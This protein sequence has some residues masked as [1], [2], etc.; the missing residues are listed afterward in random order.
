MAAWSSG[1][2][3]ASGARG[4][5]CVDIQDF[6]LRHERHKQVLGRAAQHAVFGGRA[7]R[8]VK[9]NGW[10]ERVHTEKYE[11]NISYSFLST[12]LS[13]GVAQWLAC[14]AH[15]P[16]VRGSKPRSAIALLWVLSK[17]RQERIELPT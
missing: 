11:C 9:E 5:D 14:W 12:Y 3:L 7:R 1:M 10:V 13:S 17:M 6:V 2:I 8:N 4:P 15:N 16:N